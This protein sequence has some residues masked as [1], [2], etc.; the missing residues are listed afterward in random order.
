MAQAETNRVDIRFSQETTWN[1]TPA[2]PTM[3][4][5]PYVSETIKYDKQ[6]VTSKLVRADRLIE[7][8][9]EVGAGSSGEF[10]FEHKFGDFD[11]LIEA[12][13]G[14]DFV[15]MTFT[16]TANLSFAASG[17]GVQVVTGPAA[18]FTNYVDGTY[19]RVSGAN[20]ANNGVFRITAH[21]STTLTYTNATGTLQASTSATVAVKY[22][23]TGTNKKSFLFEK[24]FA[25][26]ARFISFRGMRVGTMALNF[27]SGQILTGSFGLVGAGAFSAATTVSG[28]VTAAST[29]IVSAASSNMGRIE[30][31]GIVLTTKIKSAKINL[32][33]NARQLTGLGSKFPIGINYGSFD[34]TGTIEA[35]FED[36]ALYDKFIAHTDSS[37]VVEIIDAADHRTIFTVANLKF[38]NAMPAGAGLNQDAMVSLDFVAKRNATT[39]AMMQVDILT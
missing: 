20:A 30:E 7:D 38:T 23:R 5:L 9:I 2:T 33:T 18:T 16:G 21:A 31:G 1:E 14:M 35:Y 6:T 8:V 26:I 12:A 11:K 10:Q 19:V 39:N 32:N 25:D 13:L 27:E 15:A 37:L 36:A 17:A 22:S 24:S 3:A 4:S 29:N 28:S 34:I